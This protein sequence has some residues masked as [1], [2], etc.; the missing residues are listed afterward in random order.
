MPSKIK[1]QENQHY[2]KI[3]SNEKGQDPVPQLLAFAHKLSRDHITSSR[4]SQKKRT[5]RRM[6]SCSTYL[7]IQKAPA[8]WSQQVL[9]VCAVSR[10]L[11]SNSVKASLKTV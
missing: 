1:P 9:T 10:L 8:R 4:F 3:A 2:F 11:E 6:D 5:H 7:S